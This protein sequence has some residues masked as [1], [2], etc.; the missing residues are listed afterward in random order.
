L[1]TII[2]GLDSLLPIHAVNAPGVSRFRGANGSSLNGKQET[3]G[4]IA[5]KSIDRVGGDRKFATV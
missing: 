4:E 2:N 5:P 1:T 3:H